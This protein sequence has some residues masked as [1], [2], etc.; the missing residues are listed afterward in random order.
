MSQF[1]NQ[2]LQSISLPN[3]FNMQPTDNDVEMEVDTPPSTNQVTSPWPQTSH[4]NNNNNNNRNYNNNNNYRN[5]NQVNQSQNH[6]QN[7][8]HRGKPPKGRTP[9]SRKDMQISHPPP[10]KPVLPTMVQIRFSNFG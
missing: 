2:F 3:T 7:H 8:Q 6:L 9:P 4:S 5:Q 1:S 10:P